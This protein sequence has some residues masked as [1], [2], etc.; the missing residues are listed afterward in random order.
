MDH[1]IKY[2]EPLFWLCSCC[3]VSGAE[4]K[5]N[6]IE[7]STAVHRKVR[8]HYASRDVFDSIFR[9]SKE[10]VLGYIVLNRSDLDPASFSS[11]VASRV[12]GP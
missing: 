8:E 2:P 9:C 3:V 7:T 6:D 1:S 10:A 4:F 12:V 5:R 11:L